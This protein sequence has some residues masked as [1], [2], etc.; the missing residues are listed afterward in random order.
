MTQGDG[1]QQFPAGEAWYSLTEVERVEVTR[2][3][4]QGQAHPDPRVAEAARG[5]A[6]VLL[7]SAEV[8]RQERWTNRL[9]TLFE[10]LHGFDEWLERR[11]DRRWAKRVIAASGVEQA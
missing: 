1:Q 2:L 5:W 8:W 6:E 7:G 4:K 3:A 9:S 11:A 10:T